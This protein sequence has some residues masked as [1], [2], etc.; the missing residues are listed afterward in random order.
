M[1]QMRVGATAPQV[2]LPGTVE[3]LRALAG[4]GAIPAPDAARLADTHMLWTAIRNHLALLGGVA[5]DVL[6]A[7]PRRLRALARG[8]GIVD[9]QAEPAEDQFRRLF[10]ERMR[11]TR[12]IVERLFYASQP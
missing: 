1:L 7:D 9:T 10:D 4:A 8:V 12:A 2:R 11:E 3:A 5:T 6:P